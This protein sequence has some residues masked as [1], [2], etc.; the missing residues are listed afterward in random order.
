MQTSNHSLQ[1]SNSS[2]QTNLYLLSYVICLG[3][4]FA[5]MM[6]GNNECIVVLQHV[7]YNVMLQNICKDRC[8]EVCHK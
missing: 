1:I 6:Q 4:M 5:T 7:H 3:K 2:L 8:N